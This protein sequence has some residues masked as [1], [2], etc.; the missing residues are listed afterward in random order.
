MPTDGSPSRWPRRSADTGSRCWSPP[1]TTGTSAPRERCSR[2]ASRRARAPVPASACAARA[3]TTARPRAG[4]RSLVARR[5]N[6]LHSVS[7]YVGEVTREFTLGPEADRL[8]VDVVIP[9]FQDVS[10]G[11][12]SSDPRTEECL[13]MLPEVPFMLFV[14]AFRKAKGLETLF[15]AYR[16]L[17]SPPPLA[18]IGTHQH[19]APEH[20]PDDV[21]TILDAPHKA[22]L[23]AWD[24]A[25]FGVMPSLWPEPLG[26]T[27]TEAMSRGKAVIGSRLG[28]HA[29]LLD[30]DSGLTV[31][32]GDVGALTAAMRELIAD[33]ERREALG[34]AA[35]RRARGV[36]APVV[37]PRFEQAYRDLIAAV[38][39]AEG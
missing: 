3:S 31:P 27:V 13:A 8:G 24:R 11:Q 21:V 36:T 14:G 5:M 2:T 18:L 37:I 23:A 35:A 20:I 22:V 4:R 32:P 28:G 38:R 29:D 6:G 30:E 7:A 33:P 19:D 39:A 10:A 12:G 9:S 25:L 16:R 17:E 1:A 15:E 34:A 26:S